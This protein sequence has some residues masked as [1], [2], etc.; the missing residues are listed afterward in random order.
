MEAFNLEWN[1]SGDVMQ[2]LKMEIEPE[3]V[4]TSE[5]GKMA[6][7]SENIDME[8]TAKGG[9]FSSI[10]RK[11]AGE[12]LFLVDFTTEGGTGVVTFAS[13]IPGKIIPIELGSGEEI[14]AQKDAFLC[15]QEGR[16]DAEFTKKLGAGFLGGEGLI[17]VKLSG[18]GQI[19]LN[20]GGEVSE[21]ELEEDQK[22][23]IDT[24]CLAAFEKD[25]DYSVDRVK[26][27]K[28]IIWGGE[29]LFLAT[30]E[31]PGRVWIQSMPIKDLAGRISQYIPT[32]SKNKSFSFD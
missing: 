20:V 17:L 13:E 12:S 2:L 28:N 16:I 25:M 22:I 26:G 7:M 27:I 9:I 1:L 32:S 31:G 14:L 15:S 8:T 6:Y 21:V 18:P 30:V 3:E 19:F 29:G 10:K 24:G 11:L 4:I 5:S 23:R